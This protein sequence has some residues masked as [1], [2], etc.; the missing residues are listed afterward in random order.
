MNEISVVVD[1]K[2]YLNNCQSVLLA[3]TAYKKKTVKNLTILEKQI[4][5]WN[6]WYNM[7]SEP[8]LSANMWLLWIL[9][10]LRSQ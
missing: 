3:K 8:Q 9:P 6:N 2:H 10:C 4:S 1:F 5:D 7:N